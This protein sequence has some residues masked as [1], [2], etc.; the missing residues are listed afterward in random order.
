LTVTET[1]STIGARKAIFLCIR[2][3]LCKQQI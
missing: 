1:R 3:N 2:M